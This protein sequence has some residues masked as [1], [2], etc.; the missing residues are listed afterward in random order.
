MLPE[1]KLRLIREARA[2]GETVVM[3]GDGL[4]DAPA[5]AAASVGIALGCGADVA[6]WSGSICLLN[7]DLNLLPW[8]VELSRR[9]VRTIR[10]NLLWAFGYN[11]VCIPL[12]A[13]GWLHPAV[14]AAA[15][16]VSSLLVVTN[17][18]RLAGEDEH[19]TQGDQDLA[20]GDDPATSVVRESRELME[21]VA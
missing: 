1:D 16:V 11:A 2:S 17:S 18:L 20:A 8:M 4:N 21:P 14:A 10:W 7:D 12:A 6:R 3:T 5:L 19:A 15:M 13:A 9:T